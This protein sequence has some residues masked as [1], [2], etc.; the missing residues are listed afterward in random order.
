MVTPETWNVPLPAS[1]VADLLLEVIS[2]G[3]QFHN[4]W[5]RMNARWISVDK[6]DGY[7][8][9]YSQ[10]GITFSV[11]HTEVQ[12][13]WNV[14]VHAQKPDFVFRRKGRVHLNRRGAS[15]H[16]TTGRQVVRISG[17]NAGYTMFRDRVKGTGYP[18]HSPV[19]P[20]LPLLCVTVCHHISTGLY[21]RPEA[22]RLTFTSEIKGKRWKAVW[23]QR[24]S[25]P[26]G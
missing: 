8:G 2:F 1:Q 5:S 7:S 24:L 4:C 16:S 21:N 14:M 6:W 26:G 19:S 10:Q 22:R 11:H 23:Q 17:S 25:L 12:T 18:L 20:S 9:F 15:V 3:N 13:S